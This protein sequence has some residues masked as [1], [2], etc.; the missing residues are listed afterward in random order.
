MWIDG[1]Q[2]KFAKLNQR[3]LMAATFEDDDDL[4]A[5]GQQLFS[6]YVPQWTRGVDLVDD[7]HRPNEK[8]EIV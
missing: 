5:F 8:D 1:K 7:S 3:C 6:R 4:E 2:V